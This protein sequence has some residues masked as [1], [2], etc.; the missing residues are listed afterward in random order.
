MRRSK[1]LPPLESLRVFHEVARQSGFRKA[2]DALLISQS[3]VSHHIRKLE[4]MLGRPL[5]QRH[6]KSISLTDAGQEMLEATQAGFDLIAEA[7][8]RL[9]QSDDT[10][11]LRI[12]LLPSFATNWLLPR[13]DGFRTRHSDIEVQLDPTL[14]LAD[15]ANGEADLAIRY[16]SRPLVPHCRKLFAEEL[17]PAVSADYP[18]R[19]SIRAPS[20]VLAYPLLDSQGSHDWRIWLEANGLDPSK[21]QFMQ[22]RDYNVVLEAIASGLGIGMARKRL[23]SGQIASG[24]IQPCFERGVITDQASHWL[25]ARGDQV[26]HPATKTFIKWLIAECAD[27]D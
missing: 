11:P 18:A 23:V 15:L 24:R 19:M 10:A 27:T 1:T 22:L 26:Q 2:G 3:A 16:G 4:D 6:S 5:F 20:D 12:S 21:G 25:I 8:A 7:A 13:I 9:R 14:A 17:C